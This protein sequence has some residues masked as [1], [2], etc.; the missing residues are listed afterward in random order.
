[1]VATSIF[2]VI[3]LASMGALFTLLD[4]S[5]TSRAL[6][7]AM[8]NV[9]FAMESMTRSIR[10]GTDY[11]C[12]PAETGASPELIPVST[13]D[14]V[15][16]EVNSGTLIAF[17]PQDPSATNK[18][19]YQLDSVTK[20]IQVMKDGSTWT[21]ITSPDVQIDRLRFIVKGSAPD[22]NIQPSVYI[23]MKGTVLVKGIPTSFA[24]QTL[25]SQRNF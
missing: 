10:M 9:N 5:K 22:D 13:Q 3:M 19:L 7:F 15:P 2:V 17:K 16:P 24:I 14:C 20:S 11:Y 21:S 25:A 12:A 18:I 1:M 23:I 6:R 8:D 4:A